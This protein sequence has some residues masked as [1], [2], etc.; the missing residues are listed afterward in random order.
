MDNIIQLKISLLGTKPLI[1][2]QVLVEKTTTFEAL[3]KIIQIVMGWT[4]SH[5][6]EFTLPGLRIGPLLDELDDDYGDELINE[7]SVTME[8]VLNDTNQTI[9]YTY[10]F[11][12]S[13][14]HAIDMEK[15]LVGDSAILYPVCTGGELACPPEDCGGIPGFYEML[16]IVKDKRHPERQEMLAWLGEAY[17]EKKFDQQ[18]VNQQLINFFHL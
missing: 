14:L 7:A 9:D 2:R 10:D 16:R 1:W 12:D 4:N 18:T 6:H 17:N 13:W 11:G 15:R 8:S 5:L 3:H